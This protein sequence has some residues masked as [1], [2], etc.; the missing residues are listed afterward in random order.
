MSQLNDVYRKALAMSMV[1][2]VQNALVT[3]TGKPTSIEKW[4][5]LD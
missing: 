3:F 1:G 4:D 2:S 5:Y